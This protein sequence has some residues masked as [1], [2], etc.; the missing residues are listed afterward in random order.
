MSVCVCVCVCMYLTI[1]GVECSSM[2]RVFA[3]GAMG[4]QNDPSW[5]EPNELFLVPASA[6]QLV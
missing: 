4:H 2:V 6:P 5:G 1:L 3:Q